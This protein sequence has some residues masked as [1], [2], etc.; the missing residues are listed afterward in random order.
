MMSVSTKQ[1]ED[2]GILVFPGGMEG[3]LRFARRNLA[4]KRRIVGASSLAYD[5]ACGQYP[6]WVRL[7]QVTQD[8]FDGELRRILA[9]ERIDEVFTPHPV[10]WDYLE[11]SLA[12]IAP[13]VRLTHESV[14]QVV[15]E[16]GDAIAEADALGDGVWDL[17]GP[18]PASPPLLPV[19]G[20]SLLHFTSGI[21]GHCGGE[22]IWA[23]AE[24][25]RRCPEGDLVEIGSAWGKSA[26]ALAWL[27]RRY[28]LGKLLCVDPWSAAH[29]HQNDGGGGV[30]D[31]A[32]RM[33]FD[34]ALMVFEINLAGFGA[35][36][37]NYLRI[38]SHAGAR[39]Y[40]HRAPVT[41]PV[42][43]RTTYAGRI[44]L[45]HIDG[46]HDH[47]HVRRDTAM[48]APM[49]APGGWIVFDDYTWA[50]GDGPKRVGDAFLDGNAG[51]I[52][53]AFVAGTAL[54]VRLAGEVPA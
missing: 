42:F 38:P 9:E 22:K 32:E 23:L 41:T 18:A 25:A 43:G 26:Y 40:A 51:R 2:A 46:N 13:G 27:A 10:I 44:A 3:S 19:E 15:A 4:A 21:P 31:W 29:R 5:P 49:V 52:D 48:W 16:Y 20:C 37:V 47:D 14:E 36:A 35:G 11:R 34:A 45:L 28:G 33:D 24:A 54:F 12:E 1:S 7:P 6:A 30:N 39:V 8:G 50:F 53:T 17:C